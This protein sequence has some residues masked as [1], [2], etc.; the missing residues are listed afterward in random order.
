MFPPPIGMQLSASSSSSQTG[1]LIALLQ[2]LRW[3]DFDLSEPGSGVREGRIILIRVGVSDWPR[4]SHFTVCSEE[5]IVRRIRSRHTAT[6][7]FDNGR[8]YADSDPV[9]LAS[10]HPLSLSRW[11]AFSGAGV[12]IDTSSTSFRFA[13]AVLLPGVS[14]HDVHATA[15]PIVEFYTTT[16]LLDINKSYVVFT[17]SADATDVDGNSTYVRFWSAYLSV[18]MFLAGMRYF[19]A[20]TV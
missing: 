2:I 11:D 16:S 14:R 10:L 3:P 20:G 4:V 18:S 15:S 7:S 12:Q 5:S 1:H 8:N 19:W 6:H 9:G 13:R 17:I